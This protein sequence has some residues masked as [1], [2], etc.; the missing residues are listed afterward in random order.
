MKLH[1]MYMKDI[2]TKIMAI[3]TMFH[4]EY[5]KAN[6]TYERRDEKCSFYTI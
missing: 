3:K 6:R 5:N 4:E 2:L 1:Y